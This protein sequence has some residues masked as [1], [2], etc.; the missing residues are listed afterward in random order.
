MAISTSEAL[1]AD[2]GI[3]YTPNVICDLTS[4]EPESA[5]GWHP[6]IKKAAQHAAKK[7]EYFMFVPFVIK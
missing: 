4:V 3:V 2:A 6:V 5:F 7:C 1:P